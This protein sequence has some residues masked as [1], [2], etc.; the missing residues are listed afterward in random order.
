LI[1]KKEYEEGIG[2]LNQLL[3]ELPNS[4]LTSRARLMLGTAQ[5]AMGNSD[6]AL[7]TLSEL[8]SLMVEPETK[9]Q[10]LKLIGD[11][12]T[13]KGDFLRAIQAWLEEG[14][15]SPPDQ[16]AEP[17]E[18]IRDIVLE[19]LDKKTLM[20]LKDSFPTTFPG[21]LALIRLIEMQTTRGEES[22]AERNIRVFLNRFPN[23]EYAPAATDMLR[24]F[25]TKL[26]TSQ[27]IIVAVLPLSGRLQPFGMES[28]NGIQLALEKGKESLGVAVGLKVIDS[29]TD[30]AALR[31]ELTEALAEYRPL[32]VIGPLLSRDLQ[33]SA[34]LA[35][36]T[37]IPFITPSATV[38]EVRR[39]SDY[40]FST[41]M[42]YAL[43]A[44]R[45]ADYAIGNM[46]LRRFCI[47]YPETSYGQK[48]AQFF[49]M[50]VRKRGGE[51]IAVESFKETDTDFGPQI[52]R[53]KEAD[54]KRYGQSS[55]TK[56]S[57]GA[58]RITYTPG[59][60]A[61]FIPAG[62]SHVA[63]IAPQLA[64]YDVKVPLLGSNTWNAPDLL[65]LTDRWIEGSTFVDG[66][67]KDS[68]DQNVREFVDRYRKRYQSDPT[69]FAAQAFDAIGVVLEAI[70]KGA[71]SSQ[72]V[73]EQLLRLQDL[74]TLSGPASFGPG[75]TLNRRLF[76]IYV[77]NGKLVQLN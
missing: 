23:H 12:H 47:L 15:L 16:Q 68:P 19:K 46:G 43:Q 4:E 18:R 26:K 59:F 38:S 65:R 53:I 29:E 13:Q 21:D 24:S 74:P 77:K 32:A 36:Q 66:F 52:R 3:S 56:T 44:Q 41:A 51:L 2:Y 7:S 39:F 54:L 11:I 10:A 76:V 40:L 69:L 75:G 34:G 71:A 67:F 14:S 31:L 70:R 8:R 28:L 20:R 60:D 1:S 57:K 63:L 49:S 42:T 45:I 6:S 64:F 30:K 50:E 72:G 55:T 22:L 27:Q 37:G 61:L 62:S 25:Q 5:L 33:M 9:R 58:V 73:Y 17:R 35:E 48:L